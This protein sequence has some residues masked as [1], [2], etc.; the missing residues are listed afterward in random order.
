L[1]L[2][3]DR[4]L[5]STLN[6]I[7]S[8]GGDW[9][10]PANWD[11]GRVPT[12]ADD[13]VINFSAITVTHSTTASDSVN[14]LTSLAGLDISSGSLTVMSSITGAITVNGGTLAGGSITAPSISVTTGG[15]LTSLP[16]TPSQMYQLDLTV[17]GTVM[18]DAT[19]RIDV[20]GKGYLPGRTSG[21]TTMGAATGTQVGAGGITSGGSF[22]GLGGGTGPNAV[23]G[24]YADPQDWGSGGSEFG[25]GGGLVRLQAQ[26]LQ[27]DGELLADGTSWTDPN[28]AWA[29][30]SGGGISVQVATLTGAGLIR[31]AGGDGHSIGDWWGSIL[32]GGGGGG[33]IAVYAQDYTGFDPSHITAPGGTTNVG[34]VGGAGTVFLK[35]TGA[36]YGTLIV[37]GSSGGDG[38]TPL[39]LPGQNSLAFTDAVVIR[40]GNTR[41]SSDHA[42]MSFDFQNSL[43]VDN[44]A[45]FVADGTIQSEGPLTV[46]NGANV[47]ASGAMTLSGPVAITSA[48]SLRDPATITL[49]GTLAL[50][51]NGLL[52][53]SGTLTSPSGLTVDGGILSGGLITVPSLTVID[54]GV[55]TSPAPSDTRVFQ[56]ELNI[57][58]TLSVDASSR[59]DVT[60]K[61]YLPGRTSGNTITGGA[62][63]EGGG[64]YGGLGGSQSGST[65]GVYGDYA[66]PG[67]W[68][69]GSGP[70]GS[71]P[72][73]GGGMMRLEAG[74]LHLDGLISASGVSSFI[75]PL[76]GVGGG[77]G[78]GGSV[79][80]S[81]QTL[82]GA[83][84]I[85]AKG[86]KGAGNADW[87]GRA[88]ADGG[89]GGRIA[90]YTQDYS[91]FD[92]SHITASGGTSNLG[93]PG[94][95]GT[96]FLKT[97]GAAHGTLIIDASSGGSG[98]T[99]LGLPGQS[100]FTVAD[101]VVIRGGG[102]HAQSEH[103]GLVLD[104]ENALIIS[105]SSQL[106]IADDLHFGPS[107]SLSLTNRAWL[108]VAG[109]LTSEVPLAVTTSALLSVAQ[110]LTTQVPV[111]VSSNGVL[112]VTGEFSDQ[113]GLT[114][115]SGGLVDVLGPLTSSLALVVDGGTLSADQVV[116]PALSVI[117]GGVVTSPASTTTEMH[118]L[119]IQLTGTLLVDAASRI[120]VTGKGYLPGRTTGNTTVGGTTGWGVGVNSGISGGSYGG[121]G[122]E[123]GFNA[124]YGDY[125]DPQDWG[126]GGG[127]FGI[128]GGLVRL[129]AQTL[130]LDGQLL[131]G[132]TSWTDFYKAW[133]G[134]SG[135]GIA[136]QVAILTG[137]G[138][139]RV[140]GG[141]GHSIGD[142]WGSIRGGGGGGGRIAV[143]AQDYS[144]FDPSHITAPPGGI[145]NVGSPGGAGTVHVVRG[146]L[147]THVSSYS[148]I[149]RNGGFVNYSIDHVILTFNKPIDLTSFVPSDFTIDGQMGH[150][151]AT[152]MVLVGNATYRIDFP[153]LTEN[154][155]YHFTLLPTL[156]DAQGF[157]LDQNANGIPGEPDDGFSFDLTIDTVDPR[158]TRHS[159]AGDI[160]GTIDH[161]DVWFSEAID[162]STFD[163]SQ[164]AITRPDGQSLAVSAIQEVGLNRFR[165]SF[166]PQT[167]VGTYHV[168]IGPNIADLAGN[169]MDQNQ[170]GIG[171]E[172]GV[173]VYDAS[174]NLVSVDLGLN[175]LTEGGTQLF[176][177]DPVTVSW[178]G[179]NLTGA[180]LIGDWTDGVYLSQDDKWDINDILLGTVHHSGGLSQ[181]QIY[182][183]SLTA[184]VPGVL[185]GTYQILVRADVYNQEGN[186]QP[187]NLVAGAPLPLAFHS[188][189][190]NGVPTNGTL[191][192]SDP[193]DYFA[194]HVNGGDSLAVFLN[195]QGLT[196][197]NELYASF[198]AIPTR[199]NYDNRAAGGSQNQML[200][201]TA[202]PGGGTFYI[203]AY[204]NST[205]PSAPYQIKAETGP[206]VVATITPTRGTNKSTT[207][208]AQGIPSKGYISP[209]IVTVTG[210]GFTDQM[211][212]QF[213]GA[214]GNI[215]TPTS[216]QILSPS[217]LL[218]DLDLL[219][220]PPGDYD[221]RLT[222]GGTSYTRARAF[223][224]I[225]GGVPNLQANIVVP[226]A[227]GFNIPTKQT[228]WIEY[229]NTGDAPMP[230]PL[231]KL[232]GDHAARITADPS[233]AIPYRGFTGAPPGVTDT[234]QVLATGSGATPG[235]L[236]PGDSGRIPVYYIGLGA[237]ANYPQVNFSLSTLA[238]A[239]TSESITDSYVG[240]NLVFRTV[241]LPEDGRLVIDP[242]VHI[243]PLSYG[244]EIR[245]YEQFLTID[246]TSLDQS[247]RPESIPADAWAA[248]ASNL[249]SQIGGLW[250]DYVANLDQVANYLYTLGK[251]TNDPAKLWSF[252][253]AQ[254][255]ASLSP[256]HYLAGAM[257]AFAPAPG[258][259]LTFNRLYGEPITSRYALGPLGR[260]WSDNW[261][262]QVQVLSTGDVVL[263]GSG[264]V[265]RFFTLNRNG[266]FTASPGDFGTLTLANGIYRLTET[267]QTLWQFRTDLH[268]DFVQDTNGNRITLGYNADGQLIS[269][270]HSDGQQI[271]IAYNAQGRISQVTDPA[272]RVT[273]YLYD[274]SGE[275]LISVT[276]PGN[277][278]TLY[279]YDTGANAASEHALLSVTYPDGSHDFFSYDG[280][281]RL[282]QTSGDNS[283]ETVT[284]NYGSPGG[285]TVTDSTGRQMVMDFGLGGQV[286]QVRDGQGRLVNLGYDSSFQ[287][288]QVVG[289]DGARYQ[290]SFDSH[291]NLVGISNPLRQKTAFAYD[292]TFNQLTSVTDA[293]GNGMLYRYDSHGNLTAIIYADGTSETFTFDAS[294]NVLTSTNRRGETILRL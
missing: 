184:D 232:H 267:D 156:L 62:T 93:S 71:E 170:N 73:A 135:G 3:E 278:V 188:L 279:S 218:V 35:T 101:V 82:T 162:Q 141:D 148:P 130:Q 64:S 21:N 255:S 211:G 112:R 99:P 119:Q 254:A 63:G 248:I 259:P 223:T 134:G 237:P 131:A 74:T 280:A 222:Q 56:L 49:T 75:L 202:P 275:H 44:S 228:I 260:G 229:Q 226:S 183:G 231:L 163:A 287:V 78:S 36:A 106:H 244:N 118:Q 90:I 154:G 269:I 270:S 251:P 151:E 68:G 291:G 236:Q 16:S 121:L 239:D 6:W 180:P 195:G 197:G 146:L 198:E 117:N 172:P 110:P 208:N 33:R 70:G 153:T 210:A 10:T 59:I 76:T 139:I 94:G 58:G 120:D 252:E 50:T 37:D 263:H 108:D 277:R 9:D 258:L 104:F 261:D 265:D 177:G 128:G 22:G 138:L 95:A 42:G 86:G 20:T 181:N 245:Y 144:G 43:T 1:E 89:G 234:V 14:N 175:N 114:L 289:P 84:A 182:S 145:T 77:G 240:L 54:G 61:G 65:N 24:N 17:T 45:A 129:Q 105:D 200:V 15:L 179:A 55:V 132:G 8:A 206:F 238:A 168:Q 92:P 286:A 88:P 149:G 4:T 126:S 7:N 107:V 150:V 13:A 137:A 28:K 242:T 109:T 40:G 5:L 111:T 164:I 98:I 215:F 220:W 274:A 247:T 283:A 204:G 217:T 91:G 60:G 83:G 281:G 190:T 11:A 189:P 196:G 143:Y 257:D 264:G 66:N 221:I 225:D 185:P 268:L 87:W 140:A 30:G 290:C 214:N 213:I 173:D 31:V 18:V 285:V 292:P 103:T 167:L 174:F 294:G 57:A 113:A 122:G 235:I 27:L 227:V 26:T 224:V 165:I 85:E 127:Q 187:T 205:D 178:S 29:G 133:A 212:I 158:I 207:V 192:P 216:T 12:S 79:Y 39:G 124:V 276:A 262:I 53:A 80:V 241:T 171:G 32:G 191:S 72:R 194:V 100:S 46:S 2:L 169:L 271:L 97:M 102:A 152:S 160:A 246:W 186:G 147:H 38:V 115:T 219:T 209:A 159:P 249:E 125:A 233:L 176:A 253:V 282:M 288:T 284:Y 230:A 81:A 34:N 157:Q 273:G 47:S 116:A 155:P 250:A 166:A 161:V 67:E 201:A 272:G 193:A 19:S 136:V 48:G 96:V 256:I 266:T 243:L 41:V 203:L 123:R 52:E 142:W 25:V 199:L 23:Y 293:K 69:S 51:S